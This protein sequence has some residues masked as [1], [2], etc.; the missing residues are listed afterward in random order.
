MYDVHQLGPQY[1]LVEQQHSVIFTPNGWP[2]S[3]IDA[4][5]YWPEVLLEA[6][7]PG[8]FWQRRL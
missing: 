5:G 7:V 2:H 4:A 8:C 6:T 3:S 1:R